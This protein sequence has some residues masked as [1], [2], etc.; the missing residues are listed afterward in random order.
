MFLRMWCL[1]VLGTD[2]EKIFL[3]AATIYC[4]ISKSCSPSVSENWSFKSNRK[5]RKSRSFR[6]KIIQR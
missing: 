6:Y 2:V 5:Y 4:S 3:L 1:F